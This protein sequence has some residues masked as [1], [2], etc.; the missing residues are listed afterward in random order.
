MTA[1]PIPVMWSAEAEQDVATIVSYISDQNPGAA[2]RLLDLIDEKVSMLSRTP[3]IYRIGRVAGTREMVITPNYIVVYS[4]GPA[5]IR[6]L[7]VLHA[8]QMWPE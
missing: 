2:L 1:T 8:A 6:I 7:R 5:A 3:T 4:E